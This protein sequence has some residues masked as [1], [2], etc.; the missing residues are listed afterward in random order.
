MPTLDISKKEEERPLWNAPPHGSCC[1]AFRHRKRIARQQDFA[2]LTASKDRL[3]G[4]KKLGDG[5]L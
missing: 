4:L 2:R 3:K 5:L 1:L